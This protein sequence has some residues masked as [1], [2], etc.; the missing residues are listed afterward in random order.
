MNH[1][2]PG[3][4]F[5]VATP[6]GHRA[7]A[8]QRMIST[9]QQVSLIA[10]EDTRHS[11]P[12]LSHYDI[13]TPLCSLH[14]HN[15]H[16]QSQQLVDKLLK[17]ESIAVI[18]DAGTPGIS[19][20]GQVLVQLAHQHHIPV[21][22][23]P[24][25]NAA[26]SLMSVTGFKNGRF[27]FIGFLPTKTQERATLLK[28][29]KEEPYTLLFYEAPHR[30]KETLSTL[31]DVFGEDR[32]IVIG[33]ELTKLFEE[34]HSTTLGEAIIWVSDNPNRRKG[35]YVLAVEA[36]QVDQRTLDETRHDKLITELLSKLSLSDAVKLAVNITG[37]K[38]NFL[39]DR[40]LRL[41]T[42]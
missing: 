7:D 5:V 12:L 21:S 1:T 31:C 41:A 2:P 24:G 11:Q 16:S 30:I 42:P 13:T 8:S 3:T 22:P 32:S 40:A 28:E 4:L 15:E 14:E 18:S 36:Y 38:K 10:A 25:A 34:V 20:P 19:D 29:L 27:L 17:G 33:R 37:E 9:L 26:I 6:I 23:I 39:Y 35:E